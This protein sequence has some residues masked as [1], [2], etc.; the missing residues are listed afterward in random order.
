V[1][2]VRLVPRARLR[3]GLRKPALRAAAHGA[4]VGPVMMIQALLVPLITRALAEDLEGGDLTT[5]ATVS[6]E[7]RAVARGAAR[8]EVIVCGGEVFRTAFQLVD[9]SLEVTAELADGARA[10]KGDTLWT[11]RGSARSIL[12]AERT[13]LNFVQRMTGIATLARRY[14]DALPPGSTTRI[15]DTRKT[16]PGL[17]GLE[18]YAVRTGGAHNHRDTLGSAV[19]IKDNHIV[20]AGGITAAVK[21]A[22]DRAPHTSK[23]EVEVETLQELDEALAAGA[24]IVMLD[25]FDEAAIDEAVARA[26]GKAL[27]ELSGGITLERIPRLARAGVDVI[28]VGALTHSAPAADLG[29]D[30]ERA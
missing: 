18:R 14:V 27:V 19:L 2:L 22:H 5:E 30:I 29:L 6:P 1:Q 9:P 21:R 10:R 11:V 25:N 8:N 24:D 20:A 7:T 23:I 15:T 3:T 4:T 16:T 12:M 13:A 17:R 28:S 26:R